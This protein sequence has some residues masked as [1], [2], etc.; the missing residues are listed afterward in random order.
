MNTERF[1]E[2]DFTR[3]SAI[4]MMIA[5]NFITDLQHFRNYTSY[6]SF[7]HAFA[8]ITATIFI[9]LVGL[10]MTLSYAKDKRCSKFLK[11]G[12]FIF[13]LGL[14]IT[15]VTW[16]FIP[17]DYIRFG[18]L[19]LIGL[20]II[21]AYPFLKLKN[22]YLILLSGFACVLIGTLAKTLTTSSNLLFWIGITSASFSSVDF[23][24][25]FPWFGIVLT[26]IVA[27]RLL[28]PKG[29]RAFKIL[30][31]KFSKP[32]QWLGRHSLAIYFIHQPVLLGL[33]LL[34]GI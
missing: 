21:L 8:L 31:L 30:E 17:N 3:G 9:F 5:S 19:H 29:V 2:I 26:G 13:G 28:Y 15:T 10:S 23:F 7:W 25:L 24:P 14:I 4:V 34:L 11:R 32:V 6:S 12:A 18:V 16:L 1:W 33:M 20:S 27:G 22:N